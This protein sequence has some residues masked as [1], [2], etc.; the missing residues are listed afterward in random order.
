MVAGSGFDHAQQAASLSLD[1]VYQAEI[2][3][4]IGLGTTLTGD[5]ASGEDLAQDAFVLLVRRVRRQPDYLREP[6]WPLLRT[7]LVRLAAQRRRTLARELR[8]LI[9]LYQSD[10]TDRWEPDPALLDWQ[11]ALLKLPPRMRACV[12]LFYG[13][14]LSTASVASALGCSPRTVENQLRLARHRL[15]PALGMTR[16]HWDGET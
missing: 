13:E 5:P 10:A 3:K 16:S 8:R 1:R 2:R 7:L 11:A 12:V 4:L 6:A 15:A 14:D 9:R